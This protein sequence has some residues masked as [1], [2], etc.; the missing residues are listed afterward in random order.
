MTL[1]AALDAANLNDVLRGNGPF[2][3]FAPTDEAFARLA[4]IE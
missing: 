3:V 1:L 4:S 2:T